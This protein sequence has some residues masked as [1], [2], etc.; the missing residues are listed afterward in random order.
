MFKIT[1]EFC[2]EHDLNAVMPLKETAL[3][4]VEHMSDTFKIMDHIDRSL[5]GKGHPKSVPSYDLSKEYN[6]IASFINERFEAELYLLPKKNVLNRFYEEQK[7]WVWFVGIG[8]SL[9]GIIIKIFG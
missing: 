7:F 6:N 5:R 2:H 9:V 4:L 8:L 3:L 1:R